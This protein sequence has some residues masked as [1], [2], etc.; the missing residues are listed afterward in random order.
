[1]NPDNAE[2]SPTK[3]VE[4]VTPVANTSPSELTVTPDPT[5]TFETVVIPVG[6]LIPDSLIVTA[7][8]T[9]DLDAVATPTI[10]L[11]VPVNPCDNA[12]VPLDVIY[13]APFVS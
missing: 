4:V 8:P 2:P 5:T 10:I 11:G 12:T 1:M 13:P 6:A 7:V 3:L 9:T